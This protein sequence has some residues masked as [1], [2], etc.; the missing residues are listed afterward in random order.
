MGL[1]LSYGPET[2]KLGQIWQFF[3]SY[4]LGILRT[5]LKNNRAPLLYPFKLYASFHNH[6]WVENWVTIQKCPHWVKFD[7]YLPTVTLKCY[8]R[9]WKIMGHLFYS[10]SCFMHHLVAIDEFQ[11][12]LQSG[13]GQ[14]GGWPLWPWPL[15]SDLDLLHGHHFCQW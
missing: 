9:P 11:F 7:D 15:T 8:G 6:W 10:H 13:K 4:D 14:I 5:T 3:A 2:L 1:D 12:A